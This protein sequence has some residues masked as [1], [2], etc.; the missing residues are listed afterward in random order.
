MGKIYLFVFL[1]VIAACTST[2]EQ[3]NFNLDTAIEIVVVDEANTDLLN[4]D[5]PDA[6]KQENIR[7]FHLKNG[8]TEEVYDSNMDAERGF[9]IYEQAEQFH[10]RLFP[11]DAQ[12]ETFPITYIQW[13]EGNVD[14]IKCQYRRGNN[15]VICSKVWV[16]NELAWEGN[17]QRLIQ[18][19]K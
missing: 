7:T 15:F 3:A 5:N 8:V 12:K 2:M 16:N 1:V 13:T 9:L 4:P 19:L 14:T 18:I 6:F 17:D 10:L 11:N